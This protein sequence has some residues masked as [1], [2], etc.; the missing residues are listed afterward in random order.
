[1]EHE[2]IYVVF[3]QYGDDDADI[4]FYINTSEEKFV[5]KY[6]EDEREKTGVWYGYSKVSYYDHTKS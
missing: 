2:D 6:I 3:S 5:K 1:M 4:R